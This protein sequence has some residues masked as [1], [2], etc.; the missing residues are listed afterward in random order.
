[1]SIS[2]GSISVSGVK[3]GSQSI[4]K[5]YI[6]NNL[7]SLIPLNG[8]DAGTNTYYINGEATPLDSC[9]D[10]YW[11]RE[12]ICTS[13]CAYYINGEPYK[14]NN[15][16][17]CA[18]IW[19]Y[20]LIGLVGLDQNGNGWST[21]L[22]GA[23]VYYLGGVS[24]ADQNGE[25]TL[26]QCGNGTW[27]DVHYIDGVENNNGYSSCESAYYING[28]L[29][30]LD[31]SGN[32]YWNDQAYVNGSAQSTGW[33][34]YYYYID[35]VQTSLDTTGTGVENGQVYFN[36]SPQSTG[37]NTYHY[38]IDNVETALDSNGDGCWNGF[39]YSGGTISEE[40]C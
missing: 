23:G 1:M 15:W 37:W 22:N 21:T 25:A 27:N 33:N 10:G 12:G 13:D 4:S 36:G 16:S 40:T 6:G 39:I 20:T 18:Q 11:P 7:I 2:L 24:T 14:T 31:S 30:N 34:G 8:W 9:G 19:Y 35:N 26:N 28:E 29:T 5:I 38:Y 17:E 3:L 32:G